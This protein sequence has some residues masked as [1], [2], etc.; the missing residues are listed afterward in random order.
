MSN[1]KTLTLEQFIA[2]SLQRENDKIKF[3]DIYIESLD[4]DLTFE[5]PTNEDVLEVMDEISENK[6]VRNCVDVF[7]K[8]VYNCCPFLKE[9]QLHDAHGV[10]DPID[11]VDKIFEI[12]DIL[13]LGEKLMQLTGI[14]DFQEEIK[15]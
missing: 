10:A 7:K 14:K 8:L 15:N 6:T 12:Q 2:K 4:C 5:R 3:K 13:D 1:K 11:I 9:Q